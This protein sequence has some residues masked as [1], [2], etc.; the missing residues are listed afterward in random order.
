MSASEAQQSVELRPYKM[1]IS[2]NVLN[3][4][5]I[6]LYSNVPAVLS[7]VVANAWDADAKKVT[8]DIHKEEGEIVVY[9]TGD[10][11]DEDDINARYLNVGYRKRDDVPGETAA[12][13]EP[14][15]RKGIG[16]LSVFSIAET[17]EVYSTKNGERH[18]FRM[19]SDD[20]QRQIADPHATGDYYP[21]ALD[22]TL[23][24][25]DEGT[26]IVLKDLKKGLTRSAEYLRRRLARRFSVIGGVHGFKVVLDG[27]PIEAKDRGYYEKIEFLWHLGDLERLDDGFFVEG[28]GRHLR[29]NI[30]KHFEV[31]GVVDA[32]EDWTAHGWIGTVDEQ[33]SIDEDNNTIVVLARGKLIH[34]DVLKDLKEGGVYS[35]YL[36]GEIYADFMDANELPDIV[37]SD[38]QSVNQDDE[39][40]QK[41]K[42]YV[43]TILKSIENQWSGLRNEVGTERALQHPAIQAWYGRLKGDRKKSAQKLFGRIESLNMPDAEAKK[44]VYKSGMLAFER[45]SLNDTLSTLENLET[46]EE[47]EL[48]S[49]LFG[50]VDEI[51][52]VHYYEIARGRLEVVKQFEEVLPDAKERLLQ[53][54]IFDHLWLMDPSWERAASNQRI[55]EAVTKEFRDLDSK[56]TDEEKKGR[57]DIRYRTA[58]GK[59]IIIELKKYDRTVDAMELAAQV[60]KY[61]DALGKCLRTRFPHEPRVIETICVLGSPPTPHDTDHAEENIRLLR[62]VGARYITYD[63]LIQDTRKSY[64]EYLAKQKEVSEL[65]EMINRLDDDF[66]TAASPPGTE[67]NVA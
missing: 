30:R 14:M 52:A 44:E 24:D 46:K 65:L 60:R 15:G 6:G 47:L 41:L 25:F 62:E 35:K 9:D 2:L 32:D 13:R 28:N 29:E 11:M 12:G 63:E 16:K 18:A 34:E 31:S 54:H 22:P 3:H 56:L 4:L 48:L 17:V 55:E 36:I 49:R 43:R 45:L 57:I 42:A 38:R 8:I 5:G 67:E 37:T 61:R 23:V 19:N 59:H 10:G 1:T 58:A 53:R 66:G 51:E 21:E 27:A 39:R 26:K 40:Y 64:E 33:K 7:E 20:I 50:T